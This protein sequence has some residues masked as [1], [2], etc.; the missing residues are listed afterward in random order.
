MTIM[1]R[2]L[3][4]ERLKLRHT[5]A[6][7]MVGLAPCMVAAL[8]VLQLSLRT[9]HGQAPGS[10]AAAWLSL[11]NGLFVFWSF[12][13]LPLFV[14]LQ[15]ALLAHAEHSNACWKH[16]LALPLPAWSH[17]AAKACVLLAMVA[18]STVLLAALVPAAGWV[19][20]RAQPALGLAGAPP[21]RWLIV[22]ALECVAAAMV[23]MAIQLWVAMRWRS[24]TVGVFVGITGTV[25]GF[26]V[27]QS[28][29]LGPWFPWSMPLHVFATDGA[30]TVRVVMA[31]LLGGVALM[32]AGMVAFGRREHG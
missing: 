29:R 14:T 17:Y 8:T 1:A 6:A 31:G 3:R 10:A 15:A 27:G 16:L 32:L 22:H 26:L 25:A 13:M 9:L 11:A 18:V 4:A 21:W 12:L 24:F 28:A 7:A 20:M 19:L 23:L 30:H 5:L 2:A